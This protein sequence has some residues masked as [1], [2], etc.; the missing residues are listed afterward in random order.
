MAATQPFDKWQQKYGAWAVVTGASDGIGR[1]IAIAL[2]K[3]K[4][5]LVLVARRQ[6]RLDELA[7]QLSKE[8]AIEI[9]VIPAN[10]SDAAG[11]QQ[12]ITH[13]Q[14]LQ[15]GL[16]VACAGFGTSGRFIESNLEEELDM[17]TVNCSAVLRMV[18][19]Y[20]QRFAQQRRGGIILMSSLLAFQGVPFAANY[21]ATKAYIQSFAEALHVELA[22]AGVDII[23]SAPGP[24]HSGF[25]AR[26]NMNIRLAAKVDTVAEE[27]LNK[28][29]RRTTV[30]PG[31]LS[32]FL[33]LT[34]SISPRPRRVRAMGRIMK[35]MA[36]S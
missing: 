9:Q 8:Y 2:A 31:M 25:A 19:H 5:N 28:L 29:G 36:E 26:A 32:K 13:T 11:V 17:L 16:L 35:S 1:E 7:A 34:L 20:G 10:L 12:V 23:A 14:S 3:R 4:L 21:A 18:H 15:V 22:P 30:R 27:T 24:I 6:A 33:E